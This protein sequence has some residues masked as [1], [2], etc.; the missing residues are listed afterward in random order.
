MLR[1]EP[2]RASEHANQNNL[3]KYVAVEYCKMLIQTAGVETECD[4]DGHL[5]ERCHE[6]DGCRVFLELDHG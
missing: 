4:T 5:H 1:V 2:D 6:A 3:E